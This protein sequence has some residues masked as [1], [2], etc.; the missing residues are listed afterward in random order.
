MELVTARLHLRPV[1]T[2]DR[3]AVVS[4]SADPRVMQWLGGVQTAEQARSWLDRQLAH[5]EQHGFGRF[6]V[7]CDGAFVGF[8]GLSR[9]EF[10]LGIVPGVEIAWRLAHEHWG[11]GYATEAARAVLDDGF[12]RL[13][14]ADIVAVTTPGNMRSRRVME[15]LGMVYSPGETFEHP[16]VPEGDPNRTHVVYRLSNRKPLVH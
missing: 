5:W 6:L 10:D 14:L 12:G 16:R 11:R 4:L 9:L 8:A 2:T 1:Q 3:A 7:A 15:R 13:G